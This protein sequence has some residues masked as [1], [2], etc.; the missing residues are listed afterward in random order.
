M[1]PPTPPASTPPAP[2]SPG[3]TRRWRPWLLAAAGLALLLLFGAIGLEAFARHRWGLGHPLVMLADPDLEYVAAPN[4]RIVRRGN[5]IETNALGMRSSGFSAERSSPEEFRVLVLGDSVMF[6]GAQT[7]QAELATERLGPLLEAR[8]GRPVAVGNASAGSWGPPNWLGWLRSRDL[9]DA[10]VLVVVLS[11][12]DAGDVISGNW[13]PPPPLNPLFPALEE[14]LERVFPEAATPPDGPVAVAGLDPRDRILALAA[15]QEIAAFADAA[16][17]PLVALHFPGLRETATGEEEAGSADVDAWAAPHAGR[18][19][20]VLRER[21]AAGSTADLPTTRF[22]RDD[23][24]PNTAGQAVL[25][26]V[27]AE[28]IAEVVQTRD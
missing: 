26:E 5:R 12:H 11:S 19:S 16:G 3:A 17:V 21:L 9:C 22:H 24:H 20:R 8:L 6:G 4:Q 28:R 14:A 2:S 23:L 10:D 1:A 7:D 18:G 13:T 25:A 15:L 27:L